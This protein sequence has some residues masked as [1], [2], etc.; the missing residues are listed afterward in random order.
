MLSCSNLS[1]SK[2]NVKDVT[3]SKNKNPHSVEMSCFLRGAR[4]R[5]IGSQPTLKLAGWTRLQWIYAE[6]PTERGSRGRDAWRRHTALA[7]RKS[8]V[9]SLKVWGEKLWFW[10][11][12]GAPRLHHFSSWKPVCDSDWS[13]QARSTTVSA[14]S[15]LLLPPPPP[16]PQPGNRRGVLLYPACGYPVCGCR[17]ACFPPT[18]SVFN[19]T[20]L[21]FKAGAS[22]VKSDKLACEERISTLAEQWGW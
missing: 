18:L 1:S 17:C 9:N 16:P 6:Q 11:G 13:W 21:T 2:I 12:P 4:E 8:A 5:L 7:S 3:E 10:C 20:S 14:L 22:A 19:L 15:P